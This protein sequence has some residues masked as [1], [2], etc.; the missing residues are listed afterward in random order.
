MQNE[1][2]FEKLDNGIIE[3]RYCEHVTPENQAEFF[4]RLRPFV[5]NDASL[6]D[7]VE[8]LIDMSSIKKY[9][10]E[11]RFLTEKFVN[12]TKIKRTAAYGASEEV[13]NEH[14]KAYAKPQKSI[15]NHYFKERDQALAWLLAERV[16]NA[17]SSSKVT[18]GDGEQMPAEWNTLY[19]SPDG[20]LEVIYTAHV[21]YEN[22]NRVLT[23]IEDFVSTLTPENKTIDIL[24]DMSKVVSFS[25]AAQMRSLETITTQHIRKVA[26]FGANEPMVII[27]S[28]MFSKAGKNDIQRNF[29]TREEALN[30]LRES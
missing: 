29:K 11:A 15:L 25:D 28:I 1:T 9:D 14:N 22:Q 6:K 24:S 3:I 10:E 4:G 13:S 2:T 26:V 20:Y 5:E 30:W 7:G 18:S 12:E 8:Y 21:D 23:E 17:Y 16:A 27:R 19:I